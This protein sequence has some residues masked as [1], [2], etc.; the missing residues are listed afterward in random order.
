MSRYALASM[1]CLL[2]FSFGSALSCKGQSKAAS[3]SI[4]STA[5]ISEYIVEILEDR[6][7]NLWF[8]TVSDGAVRFDG[9]SLTYFTT[10]DGLCDNTVVSMAEDKAGNIWFGTHAGVSM[11]DGK[12][13][14]SFTESKGLH[15]PG[16]NLLIDRNGIIWAGTNDGLFRFDGSSFV[17]FKLPDPEIT[18]PSYKWVRGKIWCIMEDSHGNLWFGR[19]GYGACKYDGES[20]THFTTKDGLCSNNV[21]SI[22][23]DDRGH[24]WF[25]SITS[26]FPEFKKEGG[27]SRYDGNTIRKFPELEGLIQNDI[28]TVYKDKSG[29]IWVGAVNFGAYRFHGDKF[30][31][32]TE[33]DRNDIIYSFGIQS[34]LEDRKGTL[35]F[36]FSGGLFR[37]DG[38]SFV[39]MTRGGLLK[40]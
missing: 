5:Q 2:F 28:Y 33:A 8:G 1:I 11:F 36:G 38:R 13:F 18:D 40:H 17:E 16:C 24:I 23:E 25:G 37:F 34:I 10:S 31:L 4:D 27:L 20:Y 19:D 15:G 9:K 14:T 7:G 32:V 29:S 6:K 12:T 35:W 22:A 3:I 30:T 26:D 21:A 39:N